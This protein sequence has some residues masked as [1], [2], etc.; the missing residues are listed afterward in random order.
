MTF[1]SL[2]AALLFWRRNE[3]GEQA[4]GGEGDDPDVNEGAG[5]V[6]STN[7]CWPGIWARM[8][9]FPRML[10][11]GLL[12]LFVG[13]VRADELTDIASLGFLMVYTLVN[14]DSLL[15]T[16]RTRSSVVMSGGACLLCILTAGV[17]IHQLSCSPHAPVLLSV[18]CSMLMLP[19]VW[20]AIYYT[21]RRYLL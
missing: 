12:I 18:S 4:L 13:L 10:L 1:I 11:V 9:S 8:V 20:P 16:V 5:V 2:L 15:I 3:C 21:V 14:F 19:F 6:V 17:V 7:I